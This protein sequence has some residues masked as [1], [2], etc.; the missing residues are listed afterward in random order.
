[1]PYIYKFLYYFFKKSSLCGVKTSK[2]LPS[3][4]ATTPCGIL[5]AT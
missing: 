5:G 2:R 3:S 4:N 1:V